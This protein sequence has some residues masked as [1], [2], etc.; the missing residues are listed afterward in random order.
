MLQFTKI[1]RVHTLKRN[2]V[3]VPDTI[4]TLFQHPPL[5][6]L[7]LSTGKI[8]NHTVNG[9]SIRSYEETVLQTGV[10]HYAIS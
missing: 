6:D 5:N 10:N 8:H 1:T 4:E 3:T 7:V 2:I 9:F